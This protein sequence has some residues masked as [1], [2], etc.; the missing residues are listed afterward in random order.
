MKE[1]KFFITAL[2]ASKKTIKEAIRIVNDEM[3]EIHLSSGIYDFNYTD[4]YSDEFGSDLKKVILIGG[5]IEIDELSTIK[6]RSIEIEADYSN[7]NRRTMNIDP[8]FLTLSNLVLYSTKEYSSSIPLNERINVV[9]ELI[10][11]GGSYQALEWTYP[12]YSALIPF[13][14]TVREHYIKRVEHHQ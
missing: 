12:D 4:Y 5:K 13:F 9:L 2:M 7:K 8:G 10:Y 11:H 3:R 14:N 1:S 6:Y